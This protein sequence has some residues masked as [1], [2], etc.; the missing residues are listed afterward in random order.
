MK[1]YL[2]ILILL[3]LL[4]PSVLL[5]ANGDLDTAMN[6]YHQGEFKKAKSILKRITKEN[7][8]AVVAWFYLGNCYRELQD[9]EEAIDAYKK[10]MALDSSNTDVR[11]NLGIAYYK[12]KDYSNAIE[13]YKELVKIDP[14]NADARFWLGVCYDHIAR[15]GNAFEQ[16]RIL[17]SMGEKELAD[18]LYSVIFLD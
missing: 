5:S 4:V 9:N 8:D 10:A 14:K 15:V 12:E 18:K 1:R 6:L 17:K 16:Y 2:L 7:P 11:L 13:T 3:C